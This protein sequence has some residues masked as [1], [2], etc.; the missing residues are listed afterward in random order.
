MKKMKRL[1][2]ECCTLGSAVLLILGGFILSDDPAEAA[3]GGVGV[4]GTV[5]GQFSVTVSTTTAALAADPGLS[6]TTATAIVVNVKSTNANYNLTVSASGDLV[7]T[8]TPTN[9]LPIGRLAWSVS[10]ANTWTP[11]TLTEATLA[12]GALKTTG[13][14][15]DYSYDY[16]FAPLATDPVGDYTT[17]ITYTAVQI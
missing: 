12:S 16:Q 4:T 5:K 3:S 2:I 13:S 9:T 14:G 6:T 7:D 15:T 10:G 11:F 1:A 8:V 17:N